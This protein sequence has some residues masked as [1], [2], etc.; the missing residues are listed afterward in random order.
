[1]NRSICVIPARGGSK[2][3]P[4][5]NLRMLAG[6]PMLAWSIEQALATSELAG[7]VYVSSDSDEILDVAVEYGGKAVKRPPEFSG[8]KA[9]SESAL[10]HVL[11]QVDPNKEN[12]D[13]VVF[14]QATSPIRKPDDISNALKK[15]RKSNSDSLLSVRVLKDYFIWNQKKE[16]YLPTNF[17]YKNRRP[18]QEIDETFLENGSIYIFRPEILYSNHNRLGGKIDIYPMDRIHSIQVDDMDDLEMCEY[19]L[20]RYYI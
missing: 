6:K 17:D 13:F 9:A 19:F 3:I 2:G 14:L 11:E 10:V 18:R 20:K 8:D 16:S 5:K 7:E 1:M 12:A 15:I 4:S